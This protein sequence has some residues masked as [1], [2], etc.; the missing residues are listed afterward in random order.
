MEEA[1]VLVLLKQYQKQYRTA[2]ELERVTKELE[3]AVKSNDRVSLRLILELRQQSISQMQGIRNGTAAYLEKLDPTKRLA[4]EALL[5]WPPKEMAESDLEK[6][7][8]DTNRSIKY[9]LTKAIEIDRRINLKLGDKK[10]YYFDK[11]NGS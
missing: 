7:L 2:L 6:K 11:G 3:Q 5:K 4:A 10:S 8:Q 9:A 1:I